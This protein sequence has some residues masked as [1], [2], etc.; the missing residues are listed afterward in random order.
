MWKVQLWR[1]KPR[2][3]RRENI[4]VGRVVGAVAGQ[5]ESRPDSTGRAPCSS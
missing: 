5:G 4:G 3:A 1:R 2:A